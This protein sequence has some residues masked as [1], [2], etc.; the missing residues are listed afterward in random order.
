L[1]VG[2]GEQ[3]QIGVVGTAEILLDDQLLAELLVLGLQ[4]D[5]ELEF[6]ILQASE[7]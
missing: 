5:G 2:Q 6:A 3:L 4:F 7:V 1:H